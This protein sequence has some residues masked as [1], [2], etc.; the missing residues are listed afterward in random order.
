MDK[1]YEKNLPPSP[2]CKAPAAKP[3]LELP[4]IHST[5]SAPSWAVHPTAD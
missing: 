4:V 5:R 2:K 1:K 3:E